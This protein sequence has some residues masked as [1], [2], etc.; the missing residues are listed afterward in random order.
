MLRYSLLATFAHVGFMQTILRSIGMR[1]HGATEDRHWPRLLL[2]STDKLFTWPQE[3]GLLTITFGARIV[4]ATSSRAEY[5][6]DEGHVTEN[7]Q[8]DVF[9]LLG[10]SALV[11]GKS[12]FS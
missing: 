7:A 4:S 11:D 9:M 2:T 6:V 5:E 8:A 12:L 3:L 10:I 1:K